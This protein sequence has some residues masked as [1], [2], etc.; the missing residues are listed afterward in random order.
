[1][2]RVIF[3]NFLRFFKKNLKK[4]LQQNLWFKIMNKMTLK[5]IVGKY[6]RNLLCCLIQKSTPNKNNFSHK[7]LIETFQNFGKR[8]QDRVGEFET[9]DDLND[10]MSVFDSSLHARG[11]P[12]GF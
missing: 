11:K 10:P 6:T 2:E 3:K 8:D 4:A 1:M 5:N 12:Q 7:R 9:E